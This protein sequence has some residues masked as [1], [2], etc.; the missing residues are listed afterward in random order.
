MLY[1]EAFN[2][3]FE[4]KQKELPNFYLNQDDQNLFKFNSVY[5][6]FDVDRLLGEDE[7]LHSTTRTVNKDLFDEIVEDVFNDDKDDE[8]DVDELEKFKREVFYDLVCNDVLDVLQ[9][10]LDGSMKA[11][12]SVA[13]EYIKDVAPGYVEKQNEAQNVNMGKDTVELVKIFK[14]RQSFIGN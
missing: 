7:S 11:Q 14:K 2:K 3:L 12:K 6:Y 1:K 9:S 5:D 8:L 10:Y 13:K 4:D